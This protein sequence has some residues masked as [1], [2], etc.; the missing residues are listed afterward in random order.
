MSGLTLT[1]QAEG[2]DRVFRGLRLLEQAGQDPSP[3][4]QD[5]GEYMLRSTLHRWRAEIDPKGQPWAALSPAYALGKGSKKG[6][7]NKI[8]QLRGRLIKSVHWGIHGKTL[9]LGTN[10]VYSR[11]HQE[12]GKAG[13]G[14]KVLI[15]ARPFLGFSDENKRRLVHLVNEHLRAALGG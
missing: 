11:I 9:F 5:A 8:L 6:G 12:G 4:L 3:F 2:F 10:V 15:P 1:I 14:L 13:R 7:V